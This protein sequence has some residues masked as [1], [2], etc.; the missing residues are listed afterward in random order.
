M[1]FSK[2]KKLSLAEVFR[3]QA[4]AL[5]SR[6]GGSNSVNTFGDTV[7]LGFSA[8]ITCPSCYITGNAVVTTTGVKTDDSLLQDIVNFFK[9]PTE[10]VVNALDLNLEVSLENFGGH[11]E[12]DIAF[13]GSGTYTIQLYK[14]ETPVGVQVR[15]SSFLSPSTYM[16]LPDVTL[17]RWTR[18]QKSTLVAWLIIISLM[19]SINW[20]CCSHSS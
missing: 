8:T 10:V 20:G 18:L 19:K 5:C 13:A 1:F 2:C 16:R 15:L 11:F 17:L 12:F 9:D 3:A 4:K 14:S 7:G 6:L